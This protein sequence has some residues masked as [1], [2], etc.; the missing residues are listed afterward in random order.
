[1]IE[2]SLKKYGL[3]T[4]E[5]KVYLATL[6]LGS[7]SILEISKKSGINRAT[8]YVITESLI[9]RGLASSITKG[10]KRYFVSEDPKKLL[11]KLEER[12]LKV[13]DQINEIKKLIPQ[14]ESIFNRS[15]SKPRVKMYEGIDGLYKIYEDTLVEK[16]DI[17]A[18]IGVSEGMATMGKRLQA[19]YVPQRIKAGIKA[20]VIASDTKVS[21]IFQN[22]DKENFRETR[23]IPEDKYPFSIEVDIYSNKVAFISFK[24]R[25]LIGVIIESSEIAKTMKSI[26]DLSWWAAGE[27]DKSR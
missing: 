25:E 17:Y 19:N 11:T 7:S 21:R 12:K 20:H 14:L 22:K 3:S 2:S 5:I 24:K 23:L 6:E 15:E 8:T 10:K 16:K 18:F 1:M 13:D 27:V 9:E 26:F 4:K